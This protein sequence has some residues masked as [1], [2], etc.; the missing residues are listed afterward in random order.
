MNSP[1][2]QNQAYQISDEDFERIYSIYDAANMYF[3]GSFVG[4]ALSFEEHCQ[5]ICE[6]ERELLGLEGDYDQNLYEFYV[7]VVSDI[8]DKIIEQLVSPF[9]S[10]ICSVI[11]GESTNMPEFDRDTCHGVRVP[12]R[13][14]HNFGFDGLECARIAGELSEVSADVLSRFSEYVEASRSVSESLSEVDRVRQS[15]WG[16]GLDGGAEMFVV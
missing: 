11:K 14:I 7:R 3:T 13:A 10:D 15:F 2:K 16:G 1:D 9:I 5:L 6:I 12:F 4:A 8:I